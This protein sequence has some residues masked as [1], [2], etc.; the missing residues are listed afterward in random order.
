MIGSKGPTLTEEELGEILEFTRKYPETAM[1]LKTLAS[2]PRVLL[3]VIREE[4]KKGKL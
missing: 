3:E 2:G 4:I 1:Q